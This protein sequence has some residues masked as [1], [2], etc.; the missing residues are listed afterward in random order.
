MA[1]LRSWNGGESRTR[2]DAGGWARRRAE[3]G[4]GGRRRRIPRGERANRGDRWAREE[5]GRWEGESRGN[6]VS[7]MGDCKI[8]WFEN[9]RG[10]GMKMFGTDGKRDSDCKILDSVGSYN[11]S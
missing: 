1:D 3:R 9:K 6:R 4:N 2:S 11:N 5:K 7:E 8:F 10:D